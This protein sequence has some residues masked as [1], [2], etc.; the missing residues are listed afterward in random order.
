MEPQGTMKKCVDQLK[1]IG[2]LF[3]PTFLIAE[4]IRTCSFSGKAKAHWE[5]FDLL[6]VIKNSIRNR[7]KIRN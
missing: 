2:V 6:G 5:K 4:E 7:V 3:L 1:A